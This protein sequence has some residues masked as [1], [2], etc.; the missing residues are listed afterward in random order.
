VWSTWSCSWESGEVTDGLVAG[1]TVILF[2]EG[3]VRDRQGVSPRK[4][5]A[6]GQGR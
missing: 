3:G 5:E 6:D 1:D 2:P 4:R